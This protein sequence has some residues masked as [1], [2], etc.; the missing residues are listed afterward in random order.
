MVTCP[1]KGFLKLA[2]WT[3]FASEEFFGF[4]GNGAAISIRKIQM[5]MRN[6]VLARVYRQSAVRKRLDDRHQTQGSEPSALLQVSSI[7]S[8]QHHPSLRSSA[9]CPS[10]GITAVN[11]D[12]KAQAIR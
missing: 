2:A 9:L 8:V 12:H 4:D 3:R 11:D 10:F 5:E 7:T 6:A 1:R